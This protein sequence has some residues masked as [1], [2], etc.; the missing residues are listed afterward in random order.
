[1]LH[2]PAVIVD[3][4]LARGDDPLGSESAGLAGET[5]EPGG[6]DDALASF[7]NEIRRRGIPLMKYSSLPERAEIQHWRSTSLI[8]LDW[9]LIPRP[10]LGISIPASLAGLA[11]DEFADFVRALLAETY[12]P[13][14]IFSNEDEND[15]WRSLD[16]RIQRPGVTL[17]NRVHVRRKADVMGRLFDEVTEWL[18]KHPAVYVWKAWEQEYEVASSSL[19]HDFEESSPDWPSLLWSTAVT[20]RANPHYELAEVISRNVLHRFRPVVFEADLI[21]RDPGTEYQG[22]LHRVLHR[23]A[24]ISR[25][26]L[27]PNVLSPGDFFYSTPRKK[28]ALPDVVWINVTPACDLLR[29]SEEALD[30]VRLLLLRANRLPDDRYLQQ[31]EKKIETFLDN[32]KPTSQVIHLLF[33][34][35]V[36]YEVEFKNWEVRTWRYMKKRR[37]GR[38]LEPYVTQLQQKNALYMHRQGLPRVPVSFYAAPKAQVLGKSS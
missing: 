38:L 19:F 7:V 23:Q 26:G 22:S 34:R 28:D 21:S 17:R 33:D 37:R 20:D 18:T 15:I 2:G 32:D 4:D 14:F 10:A 13:V 30:D 1:M 9:D 29:V 11:K 36:P 24:V 16:A 25:S 5:V 6:A 12:C 31:S 3:D 27:H 35:G 8:I